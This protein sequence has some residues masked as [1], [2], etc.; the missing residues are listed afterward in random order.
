MKSDRIN[1]LQH[2]RAKRSLAAGAAL[3]AV[4]G[5]TG[6]SVT[7]EQATTIQYAASDG[8]VAEAGPLELRNVMVI[9]SGEGEPGTIL[10]TVFNPSDSAVQ[11]TI[12]GENSSADITVPAEGKWVFEDET[13]DDGILEGVSEIPGAL[14][15]LNFVVNSE[16]VELRVPV[17]D[18]TLEEYREYV[19]GGFTP[20]P[21]PTPE[22][23]GEE[24]E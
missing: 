15:D 21:T 12:E 8:I 24:E 5:A 9:T 23:I 7:S 14:V 1:P 13:T 11:L 3:V 2:T 17:L 4:L 10:G 16:T 20:D 19:P 6:C 18:G 22:E